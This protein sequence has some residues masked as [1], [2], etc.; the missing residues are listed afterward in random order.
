[1]SVVAPHLHWVLSSGT[2]I[3][4]A[5]RSKRALA[6]SRSWM[7]MDGYRR[8]SFVSTS[9]CCVISACSLT[10]FSGADSGDVHCVTF[11][12]PKSDDEY[13]QLLWNLASS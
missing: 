11:D 7:R 2:S 9:S 1:M 8:C 6:S 3:G 5:S 13:A 10:T 4:Y 12:Q